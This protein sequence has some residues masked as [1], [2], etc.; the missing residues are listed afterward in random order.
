MRLV[1]IAIFLVL[2]SACP[3]DSFA[4]KNAELEKTLKRAEKHIKDAER[5]YA[6]MD[7][8]K[9]KQS[10]QFAARLYRNNNLP[11]D[12]ARCYNGIG[13]IYIDL[14]LYEN[15][16]S[17]GFDHALQQLSEI[18]SID[19]NFKVD[20]TIVADA[21]EG[22]GRYYSS[23][24]TTLKTDKGDLTTVHFDKALEYHEKALDIRLRFNGRSSEKVA[25]SY[26]YMGQCYRGFS[27]SGTGEKQPFNPIK[28]EF[29]Y[30][31]KALEIQ[32]KTVGENA[33]Q[34][35]NTYEALGSYYYE[36][37]NDYHKGF[38]YQQ[39]ALKIR[40]GIFDS[41]HPKI[42]A[43]YSQMAIYYKVMN[44]FEEELEYLEK[45]LKIQLNILGSEHVEV[46]KSYYLLGNRYQRARELEKA[47]SYYEYAL[48]IF[49]KLKHEESAEVAETYLAIALCY[50]D[51]NKPS[52]ELSHLL[53]S[54]ATHK[55]VF[56][57]K[58]FKIGMVYIE[59]GSYYL[60]QKLYDST[61]I[62]YNLAI[63]IWQEQLGK[64]HYY[65]ADAYVK[66]A[67]V[68][69]LMGD[70]DNEFD[71]LT[72]LLDLKQDKTYLNEQTN[73][74][75]YK[76]TDANLS[77]SF[78]EE[79]TD[80]TLGQQLFKSYINLAIFYKRKK[81]FKLALQYVQ[82]AL[83]AVCNSLSK[84]NVDI[85]VNPVTNDLSH[86]IE[87]LQALEEKGNLFKLLYELEKRDG[88]LD[89]A[90]KTYYQAIEVINSLRMNFTSDDSKQQ[91]A[92][93]S[94][95]VYEET[96]A[97]LYILYKKTQNAAYLDQAFEVTEESKS[98]VLLQAL[99]N[100][101]A[102]GSS[103]IPNDL[104][105]REKELRRSL[106]YYSNYKN[107]GT[108]NN[109]QFDRAYFQ[110]K[111]AYD[112]LITMLE[113]RYSTYYNLKYQTE[114]TST[115]MV[116]SQLLDDNNMLLEYFVGDK[117]LYVFRLTK[118]K[119]DFFQVLIPHDYEK[120]VYNLRSALTNYE[121]I[122][123]YPRWAYQSFV[124]ASANFYQQ[125]LEPFMQGTAMNIKELTIIP[126]GMLNYIPFEILIS[127]A[128]NAAENGN[129][130]ALDFMLKKYQINYNYSST[131]LVKNLLSRFH[132]N[133]RECLAFAPATQ[134]ATS[135]DSLPWAKR[136]LEA[137]ENIFEG[138][139]YYGEAASKAIFKEKASEF[140]VIHLAMHGT[141][142][143]R[144]PMRSKLSFGSETDDPNK[145]KTAL[146][147]Y[148]IHN[149]PLNADLVVL[150]ACETGIG[151]SVRGEG[152]LSL[153][154]A[155]LYAGASSVV[156]TLW[157][158]ND[159]T[160]AALIETFY[161]NLAAGM[162]KPLALQQAKLT[163]LSKTDEVSGH[164][165]YWGS[166]I[167]IGN[168]APIKSAWAWW[169]WGLIAVGFFV[170]VAFGIWLYLTLY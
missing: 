108:E 123:K 19:P 133:N 72:K 65:V 57:K 56:G 46:A 37:Q 136:E 120:L 12:Y 49:R 63:K 111:Q 141:V 55:K 44:L 71:F 125:F 82:L 159:F 143:M 38:D 127:K 155:F 80:K 84:T 99:Q 87:W 157:E 144:H 165:A 115:A 39:K 77:A 81:D 92:T 98:F 167:T 22:L 29:E 13:N 11:A 148:E 6:A 75:I 90:L 137:I 48:V 161:S 140:S 9:A 110:S 119:K 89:F 132:F 134:M 121:L 147:A 113:S 135:P 117:Y 152:V 14:T 138:E 26:Y 126:D 7:Y 42:A 91:L 74:R 33:Y 24:S 8:T 27:V 50:R 30:L 17:K 150:S 142:N 101:L 96:I 107:R 129:Y 104:L 20:S 169:V 28:E 156:T 41:D 86:N 130:Q 102:R 67:Q 88:D 32:L 54:E 52:L 158:V 112:S 43:S 164:P 103:N 109:Q 106:A 35:A 73:Q 162:P 76:S 168:P 145:E 95:P 97:T 105:A 100:T 124:I 25:L 4:Q 151:K 116:Q 36:I 45:A 18:K 160:S 93:R 170:L 114:V 122:K 15:A 3:N 10:Y 23:L 166:F 5:Y 118:K 53:K 61:I 60:K 131:L 21:Y 70:E 139:Y 69:H 128:P 2:I 78:Q 16:K 1:Y 34:T 154:R 153:A 47:L 163:F 62:Y 68:F 146:F 66:M 58:H 85:Y 51:L 79:Q 83:T 31:N 149:L 59:M 94:M 40:K 64:K